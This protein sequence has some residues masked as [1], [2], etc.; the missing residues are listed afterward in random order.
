[1]LKRIILMLGLLTFAGATT[2]GSAIMRREP[3]VPAS[4]RHAADYVAERARDDFAAMQTFRPGYAFWQHVFI[5]PDHS[6]AYGSGVDG[7][8]LAFFPTKGDWGR[9]A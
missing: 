5:L 4:D 1:M 3:V 6:I 2:K 9:D 7:R 8:L